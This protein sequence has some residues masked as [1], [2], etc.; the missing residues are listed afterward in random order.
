MPLDSKYLELLRQEEFNEE[1]FVSLNH[2]QI[3]C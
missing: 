2:L 3:K 1:D